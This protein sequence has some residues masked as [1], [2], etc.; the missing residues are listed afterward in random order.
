MGRP[1]IGYLFRDFLIPA[2]IGE[3]SELTVGVILNSAALQFLLGLP[4][5]VSKLIVECLSQVVQQI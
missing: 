1:A 4:L 2:P 5:R 3:D